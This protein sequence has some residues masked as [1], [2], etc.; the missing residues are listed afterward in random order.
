MHPVCFAI[1]SLKLKIT[2][3]W[4]T[5]TVLLLLGPFH[6]AIAVPSVTHCR[7]RRRP[8]SSWTSMRRRHLVNGRAAARSSEWAQRF[9]NASCYVNMHINFDFSINRYQMA[10]L[11][12]WLIDCPLQACETNVPKIHC[13][14]LCCIDCL[15]VCISSNSLPICL[16]YF[17]LSYLLFI[18]F[19]LWE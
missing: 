11:T 4:W 13:W 2:Y 1:S 3:L 17:F 16:I 15:C 7:C 19:F 5:E 6:G 18:Y 10:S 14:F 9:S 12:Q 8:A